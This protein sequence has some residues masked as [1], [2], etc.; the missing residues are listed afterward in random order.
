MCWKSN[1][2]APWTLALGNDTRFLR[3]TAP[4]GCPHSVLCQ[5][6]GTSMPVSEG[7]SCSPSRCVLTPW[8]RQK[9]KGSSSLTVRLAL[10]KESNCQPLVPWGPC[11][12][13]LEVSS[14]IDSKG[15]CQCLGSKVP[16]HFHR[17]HTEPQNAATTPPSKTEH[18]PN[19]SVPS[20]SWGLGRKESYYS[21]PPGKWKV[22]NSRVS[23]FLGTN[24]PR[25]INHS[26]KNISYILTY[27]L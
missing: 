9:F 23:N 4:R 20:A 22:H 27:I 14:L 21:V 16:W 6:T 26:H 17:N 12:C 24:R 1:W 7:R 11:L 10:L 3:S 15:S 2:H 19:W 25:K 18:L 5:H 13:F 8:Q